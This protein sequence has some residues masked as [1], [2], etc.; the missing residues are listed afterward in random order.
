M[1]AVTKAKTASMVTLEVVTEPTHVSGINLSN[2]KNHGLAMDI[3]T[4]H[5]E[6][7]QVNRNSSSLP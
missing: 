3:S 6:K 5:V 1:E 4:D 7:E 2:L